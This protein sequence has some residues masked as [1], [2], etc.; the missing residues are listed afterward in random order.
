M[1]FIDWFGFFLLCLFSLFNMIS[2]VNDDVF[3]CDMFTMYGNN[4]VVFI[5]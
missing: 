2:Y 3:I 4:D 1:L 5:A